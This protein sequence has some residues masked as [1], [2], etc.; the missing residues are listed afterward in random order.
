MIGNEDTQILRRQISLQKFHHNSQFSSTSLAGL[1][2][3]EG[4]DKR[5]VRHSLPYGKASGECGL[6]FIGYT[7]TPATLNWRLDRMAGMDGAH[8]GLFNF[9]RPVS[10]AFF[11]VPGQAELDE[12]LG[13]SCAKSKWW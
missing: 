9:T 10:G 4:Q 8:D 6:F 1:S 11:Y 7:R 12:M 5:M 3:S 2:Q 13:A